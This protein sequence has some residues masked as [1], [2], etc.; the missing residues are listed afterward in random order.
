M[1]VI[2]ILLWI[3]EAGAALAGWGWS[4]NLVGMTLL[5]LPKHQ[6]QIHFGRQ[7]GGTRQLPIPGI[8][9]IDWYLAADETERHASFSYENVQYLLH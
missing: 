5:S 2:P 7:E 6:S 1:G 4:G 9:G 3:S 8:T